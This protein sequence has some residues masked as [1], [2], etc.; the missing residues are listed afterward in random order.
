MLVTLSVHEE[1]SLEE[2][3]LKQG[4]RLV[5]EPGPAPQSQQVGTAYM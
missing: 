5:V 4:D 1:Q 2:A 3:G